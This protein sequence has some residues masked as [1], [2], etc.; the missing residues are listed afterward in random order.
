MA[1][2]LDRQRGELENEK[3]EI[4]SGSF[5]ILIK[6]EDVKRMEDYYAESEN[7]E[8]IIFNNMFAVTSKSFVLESCLIL[9]IRE[10]WNFI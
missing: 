8:L 3:I 5:K 4:V 1:N 7:K 9:L 6:G 10:F 2:E